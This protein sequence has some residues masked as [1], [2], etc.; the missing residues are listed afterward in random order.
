MSPF[1]AYLSKKIAPIIKIIL[2]VVPLS[3]HIIFNL[4]LI[5]TL[6]MGP[7]LIFVILHAKSNSHSL[8]IN[9]AVDC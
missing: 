3:Q 6:Q 7:S 5:L 8:E 1:C 4:M 2:V 9:F